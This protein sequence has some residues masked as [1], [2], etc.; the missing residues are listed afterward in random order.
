M[1]T[2]P[3]LTAGRSNCRLPLLLLLSLTCFL[4][5]SLA[6][7]QALGPNPIIQGDH[8]DPTIIRVGAT[9]YTASTSGDWAP[10]FPLFQST[11][12]RHWTTAGAIFPTPPHWARGSFWA[13]ELV[14]DHNRILVYYVG[15]KRRGPLCIAVATADVPGG[16]FTD[17]GPIVCQ[18]DGSIDPA[19]VRD[20]NGE[21]Y[22]IWKEDGNS[23]HEPTPIWAQRLTHNLLHLRG[24]RKQILVNQPGT[25]EGGVVEAP[26]I[27][28]H[29]NRF[30]LFYAGNACCGVDCKYAEGVARADHLLGPW[31]RDPANPIIRPNGNW[32]CPGH[33][34][35]VETPAGEDYFIYHAYPANGTVY[36]GRESVLDR[37]TWSPDGWPVVDNGLGPHGSRTSSPVSTSFTDS[38]NESTLDPGWQ[39]P[40]RLN[41][42]WQLRNG[43]LRLSA[44]D[45]AASFLARSLPGPQYTASV[46][47]MGNGGI[48][49]VG[50]MRGQVVL[51]RDRD[52][53]TLLRLTGRTRKELWSTNLPSSA[54]LWLRVSSSQPAD[55][56]FSYSQD[57]NTWTAAGPSLSVRELL[58]WD[59]GLRVGL[60]N[61]G[62]S[63][64]TATFSSFNMT[65]MSIQ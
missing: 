34:T 16:P 10:V 53:L 19:M 43:S 11:D 1:N 40:V 57:G 61:D 42:R 24:P 44:T 2:K 9:Y 3:R 14:V 59:Q 25:W 52:H 60:L 26:F 7:P 22:L 32:K 63:K 47:V 45:H 33:G 48:A 38:F 58:P 5:R 56:Q 4:T 35:A 41:P 15:R 50:G 12:L 37:I 36:L 29:D 13:P 55:A 6:Q 28:R 51:Y 39:W 54:G 46:Q 17:H 65:G 18:H 49:I 8:P 23:I 31:T 64:S 27:M 30:Y 62:A 21:P 20:E